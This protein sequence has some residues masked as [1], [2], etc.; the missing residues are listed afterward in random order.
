V[1]L[2]ESGSIFASQARAALGALNEAAATLPHPDV[3]LSSLALLESQASC[4]I[5]NIVTTADALFE[6]QQ[7]ARDADAPTKE[8]LAY[9]NSLYHGMQ[10]IAK[11]PLTTRLIEEMYS[12]TIGN[13]S[14]KR[15]SSPR[16]SV[17]AKNCF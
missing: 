4:E 17:A 9:R 5:E 11:W 14:R 2:F 13:H 15:A 10:A 6:A 12:L 3:M 1:H 16:K 7:D 8:T